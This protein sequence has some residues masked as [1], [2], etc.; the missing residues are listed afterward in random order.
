[1]PAPVICGS[2]G[3][4]KAVKV[5]GLQPVTPRHGFAVATV[6]LKVVR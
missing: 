1:M 4:G 2:T 3:I 5:L 6:R